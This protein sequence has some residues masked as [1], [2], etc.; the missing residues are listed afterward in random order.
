MEWFW[1]IVAAGSAGLAARWWR[2]RSVARRALAAELE[3]VRRLTEE[4]VAHLGEQ[5]QRLAPEIEGQAVDEE[6][7]DAY[8]TAVDS[9]G[10]AR[11]DI[12]QVSK[13][14]EIA[15]VTEQRRPRA[16]RAR[17]RAGASRRR[18]CPGAAS[19]VLL[20]P[21]AR[22]LGRRRAVDSPRSWPAARPCLSAGCRQGDPQGGSRDPHGQDRRAGDA[23][24][25]C[26]QRLPA[27]HGGLLRRRGDA[28]LGVPPRGLR[29]GSRHGGSWLLR[30]RRHGQQ[31]QFRR[32]RL[33]RER[34]GV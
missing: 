14:Q 3:G 13:G 30:H 31:R 11:D 21:A 29:R 34:R 24:L 26:R 25:G 5:V 10:S 12:S 4:D 16:L 28:L 32:R 18:A 22:S 6:T 19:H 2:A 1:I 17:L 33:R 7:R 23:L 27:L 15:A 8:R 9:Y 20:R